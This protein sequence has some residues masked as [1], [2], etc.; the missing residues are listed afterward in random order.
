L[1][2]ATT[3]EIESC[4]AHKYMAH[5]EDSFCGEYFEKCLK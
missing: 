3:G 2:G 5:A 4:I 1:P